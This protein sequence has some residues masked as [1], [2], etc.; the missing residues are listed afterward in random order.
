MATRFMYKAFSITALSI[1]LS[2]LLAATPTVSPAM[3]NTA[4]APELDPPVAP[5]HCRVGHFR[6][7]GTYGGT[8]WYLRWRDN[9]SNEDGFTVETWWR[10][11][12]GVWVLVW[13]ENRPANYTSLGL[14]DNP[15]PGIKFRVK[16]FN[17][18]GDSAWSNWGH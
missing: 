5:S 15:G 9:S 13:S 16:A 12:S 18:A 1:A 17:A 11:D 4:G 6:I 7:I 14:D 8:F 2:L 10:N 3:G